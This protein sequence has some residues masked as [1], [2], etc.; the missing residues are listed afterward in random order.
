MSR[1]E[2]PGQLLSAEDAGLAFFEF[3]YTGE[4]EPLQRRYQACVQSYDPQQIVNFAQVKQILYSFLLLLLLLFFQ[5]MG[6][7]FLP[8][9]PSLT[10]QSAYSSYHVPMLFQLSFMHISSLALSTAIVLTCFSNLRVSERL[11]SRAA[12]R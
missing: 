3:K 10:M 2:A 8:H 5:I 1:T 11:R 12:V 7:F 6:H 4:Y 9:R